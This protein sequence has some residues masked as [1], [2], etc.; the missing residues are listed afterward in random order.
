[1]WSRCLVHSGP[2]WT[3]D[4]SVSRDEAAGGGCKEQLCCWDKKRQRPPHPPTPP[5]APNPLSVC[6]F[7]LILY[8]SRAVLVATLLAK[9]LTPCCLKKGTAAR[10]AAMTAS[11]SDGLTKKPF[12]PR[13]MYRSWKTLS[14]YHSCWIWIGEKV[15]PRAIVLISR[16]THICPRATIKR[17]RTMNTAERALL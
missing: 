2:V 1:M 17:S 7:F 6:G 8:L 5:P 16:S 13:I 14:V 9:P 11:E 15:S 10:L 12:S 3:W 4:L